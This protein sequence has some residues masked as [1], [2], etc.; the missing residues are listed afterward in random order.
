MGKSVQMKSDAGANSVSLTGTILKDHHDVDMHIDITMYI[1]KVP[2]LHTISHKIY[3]KTAVAFL[4][5]KKPS[6][7]NIYVQLHKGS[8]SCMRLEDLLYNQ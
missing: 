5:R 2:F 6:G 1:Q 4:N 3:F 8:S 7:N